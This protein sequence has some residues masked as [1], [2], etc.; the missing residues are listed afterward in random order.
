MKRLTGAGLTILCLLSGISVGAVNSQIYYELLD[1]GSGRWQYTYE[2]SNIGL[3][4]PIE[5][6]TIYFGHD[7][8]S[9]LLI[10]TSLPPASQWDEIV[11]QPESTL[12]VNGGYDALAIGLNIQAGE[13]VY[14]FAVSFDWLGVDVPGSQYYEIINPETFNTIEDGHTVPEPSTSLFF[15][16]GISLFCKRK[17]RVIL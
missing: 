14:G 8:Y 10:E 3:S 5:E 17:K 6:F 16:I 15:V 12:S 2:V 13:T 9:N 4:V 7:L 1:L 11:W